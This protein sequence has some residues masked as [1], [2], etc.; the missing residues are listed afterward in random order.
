MNDE[1]V[2]NVLRTQTDINPIFISTG[3]QVHLDVA[4]A[5]ALELSPNYKNI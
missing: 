1:I 4:C 5:L 3:Y 2:G